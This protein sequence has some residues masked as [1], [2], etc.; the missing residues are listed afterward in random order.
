MPLRR[1]LEDG[2]GDDRQDDG[3]RD[4]IREIQ[5]GLLAWQERVDHRYRRV[6][7]GLMGMVI[8]GLVAIVVGYGLLQGQRWDAIN[9]ACEAR[10][11]Q[12]EATVLLLR[13][14][15]AREDT[16]LKAQLRYPHTPPLA[17]RE[18]SR[19]VAGPPPDYDGPVSC[20]EMASDQVGRFRL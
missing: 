4:R 6:A 7:F 19:I 12:A 20:G 15:G 10:N 18:G 9:S 14:V 1:F 17:H 8:G 5:A 2:G 3:T 11:Q 16:V 13:D